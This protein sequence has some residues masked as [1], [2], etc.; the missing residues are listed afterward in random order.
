MKKYTALHR[1]LH[2]V[3]ALG[4]TVLF[5][6][7]F[8]RLYWM[9]KKSITAAVNND[10]NIQS[11]NLDKQSL[12]TISHALQDPMFQWHVYAA[13]IV[14]FAFIAR[15]IYM[16]AKGIRFPNP[17]LKSTVMGDKIQGIVYF[18]FYFLIAVQIVTGGV[19]KFR[20]GSE[21]VGDAS[22]TLHKLAVYWTPIFI[23]IHIAAVAIAENT[24]KKGIT[25]D[26]IG[27][28]SPKNT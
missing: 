1:L 24:N 12:R 18:V 4:M 8:L 14:T 27:G 6:T 9:G 28:D 7:G 16:I 15:I 22:E 21:S 17:F 19:M 3:L 25:S 23:F 11:L 26:M 10:A 5:A 13:Y 2:W 20:L